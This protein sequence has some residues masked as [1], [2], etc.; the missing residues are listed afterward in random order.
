[1]PPKPRCPG[2]TPRRAYM[3]VGIKDRVIYQHELPSVAWQLLW[4]LICK[5]DDKQEIRGGWRIAATGDLKKHRQ[6]IGRCAEILDEHGLI[7]APKGKRYAKVLVSRI[8][9]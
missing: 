3:T 4:W 9:G 5:M 7:E 1:M 8:T 2:C 6:W